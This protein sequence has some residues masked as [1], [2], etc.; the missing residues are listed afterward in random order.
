LGAGGFGAGPVRPR[1]TPALRIPNVPTRLGVLLRHEHPVLSPL[2]FRPEHVPLLISRGENAAKNHE[3]CT[4][5]AWF[6]FLEVK[7]QLC[8]QPVL[9]VAGVRQQ[10]LVKRVLQVAVGAHRLA[11]VRLLSDHFAKRL[12]TEID[13]GR[14]RNLQLASAA[15]GGSAVR[16]FG[17]DSMTNPPT[18]QRTAKDTG[19]AGFERM[20]L[21]KPE[22][23]EG[24][25]VSAPRRSETRPRG[26][27]LRR[28]APG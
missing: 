15:P 18:T 26:A 13:F 25:G 4:A 20:I 28:A 23:R 6:T 21:R 27:A 2:P 5:K 10:D 7:L 24:A 19:A 3:A 11:A 22:G 8:I 17:Q 16:H 12:P 1:A 9:P 14:H